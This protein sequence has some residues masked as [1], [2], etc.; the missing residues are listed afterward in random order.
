MDVVTPRAHRRTPSP[1]FWRQ[2]RVLVTG[3]TGFKGSWLCAW[4]EQLGADVVGVSLAERAMQPNL[5]DE[6]GCGSVAEIEADITSDEWQAA[7]FEFQPEVVFHLAAQALVPVGYVDPLRTFATNVHGS[8]LVMEALAKTSSVRAAVMVT[9]DKVYD[10]RQPLPYAENA[11][12]GGADPYSASKAAMELV[13]HAWPPLPCPV[14]TARAGN[15]IG[16]GDW[17]ADRLLPDLVRGFTAG[18]PLV[19]RR[20]TAVRPWQHVLEPLRGYLILAEALVEDPTISRAFNLGPDESQCVPVADVVTYGAEYWGQRTRGFAPRWSAHAEPPIE[21]T[22]LLV[23]DSSLAKDELGWTNALDW[24]S[25]VRL[26]IDWHL[27]HASG[28][29]ARDLVSAEITEYVRAIEEGCH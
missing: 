12:L 29:S 21:E 8:A 4:L 13:V 9:T 17:S 15:V 3:H 5:R 7:A 2:R 25:A 23:L 1:S 22:E 26:T 14:A 18:E 16:G 19:L 6:L 27:Q 24:R 11:F 28:V 10:I 20:P